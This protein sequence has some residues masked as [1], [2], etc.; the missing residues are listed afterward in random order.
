MSTFS[1]ILQ[2]LNHSW[3]WVLVA[4]V[5]IAIWKVPTWKVS[6]EHR[7]SAVE[8]AV[9][10]LS[11]KM[12]E[13]YSVIINKYGRAVDQAGSP[14]TL[15]EYGKELFA[16]IDAEKIVD[17]YVDR[18]LQETKDMNAYQVQEHCFLF[19]KET[20]LADL[21]EQDKDSFEK[22][23]TVAFEEGIDLEKIT[24]VVGIS[25]RDRVLPMQGKSHI[26]VD[27]HSPPVRGKQRS[28]QQSPGQF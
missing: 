8:K 13:V 4:L 24:R 6:I 1:T 19:C 11:G 3:T 12:D 21:E 28:G 5:V 18:L 7:L 2:T 22:I 23:S 9:D 10:G 26:E 27:D 14:V 20:L 25:L 15:T 16:R 17:K